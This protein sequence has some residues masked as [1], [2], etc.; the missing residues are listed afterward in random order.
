VNFPCN[1]VGVSMTLQNKS[2]PANVIVSRRTA[3]QSFS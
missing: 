1:W 2:S 3:E